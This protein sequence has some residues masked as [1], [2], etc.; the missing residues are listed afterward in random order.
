MMYHKSS[1]KIDRFLKLQKML[2]MLFIAKFENRADSSF[3]NIY[4]FLIIKTLIEQDKPLFLIFLNNN[5]AVNK[6][7]FFPIYNKP[8]KITFIE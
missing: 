1:T 4:R 3:G 6:L 2:R 8:C 7:I 5:V